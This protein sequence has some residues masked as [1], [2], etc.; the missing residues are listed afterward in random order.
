MGLRGSGSRLGCTL[1]RP[2]RPRLLG[3]I[4]L[5]HVLDVWLERE[6]KPRLRGRCAL[7]RYADD[8]VIGFERE[9]VELLAWVEQCRA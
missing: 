3:N 7:I 9:D 6:I 2:S 8:F 5:H 1:V 4:Y